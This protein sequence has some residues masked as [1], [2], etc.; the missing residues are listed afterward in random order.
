MSCLA[1]GGYKSGGTVADEYCTAAA[2]R[3]R[4][5]LRAYCRLFVLF[6]PKTVGYRGRGN[7]FSISCQRFALCF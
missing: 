2:A 1:D 3:A 4:Q 5:R 6:F 7:Y